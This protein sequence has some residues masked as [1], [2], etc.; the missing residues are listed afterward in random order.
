MPCTCQMWKSAPEVSEMNRV[1]MAPAARKERRTWRALLVR[2][3]FTTIE[4]TGR[5]N[6]DFASPLC[7]AGLRLAN[8]TC[9]TPLTDL[10]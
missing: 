7:T 9:G 3:T 10:A 1:R 4:L 8:R 6:K 2:I 5:C